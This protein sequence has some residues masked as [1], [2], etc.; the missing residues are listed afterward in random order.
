MY[1]PQ[2][3]DGKE[4]YIFV[5]Y[6]H[7]DTQTVFPIIRFLQNKGYRVWYDAGIEVGAEWSEYIADHLYDSSLVLIFISNNSNNSHNCRREINLSIELKKDNLLIY[8]E[9]VEFSRGQ[10]M[11]LCGIEALH[12]NQ[13]DCFESF[14]KELCSNPKLFPYLEKNVNSIQKTLDAV[15]MDELCFYKAIECS[16]IGDYNRMFKFYKKAGNLG[17]I[18]SQYEVGRCYELGMGIEHNMTEAVSWYLRAKDNDYPLAKKKVKELALLGFIDPMDYDLD[19]E[20]FKFDTSSFII[21][22]I[23][24]SIMNSIKEEKK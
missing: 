5:S 20:V 16:Q 19:D 13:H 24:S 2:V 7:K 21:D 11:Q 8:L 12:Y 10:H 6:A 3:Y 4:P 17:H 18:I 15:D 9:S 23:N 1:T 14:W 22:V